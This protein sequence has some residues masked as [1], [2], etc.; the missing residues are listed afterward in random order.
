MYSARLD[1]W[2]IPQHLENHIKSIDIQPTPL[3]DHSMVILE[4]RLPNE[5]RGP[6]FWHFYKMLLADSTFV[7]EMRSHI[8][9]TLQDKFEDPSLTWEWTKFKIKEFCIQY[10]IKKTEKKRST[11]K[12]YNLNST[13]WRTLWT[14][15]TQRI[16]DLNTNQLSG[17]ELKSNYTKQVQPFSKQGPTGQWQEKN[18]L[19]TSLAWK[20]G[21]Q[22]AKI[23]QH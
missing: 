18:Q 16:N 6:G 10:S 4:I 11:S 21:D 3:S 23:Y 19:H 8:Q 5:D 1:Y 13:N 17:S 20:K 14:K 12:V 15:Q 7:Q 9:T 22:K 2:F